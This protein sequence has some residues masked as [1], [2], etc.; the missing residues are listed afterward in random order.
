MNT[1]S[2][3]MYVEDEPDIQA[4]ARIALQTVGG[5]TTMICCFG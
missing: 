3:V 4:V 5:L 1:I 2:R